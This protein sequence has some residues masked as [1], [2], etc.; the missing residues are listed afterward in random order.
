MKTDAPAT[1]YAP[2]YDGPIAGW[3]KNHMK[4]NFWRCERVSSREDYLQDAYVVF[5][6]CA[7]RYPDMDTPEHFMALFQRSWSN[8]VNDLSNKATA[9]KREVV[10]DRL[11]TSGDERA[12]EPAGDSNNDGEL[13]VMLRQAPSEVKQVLN[14]FLNAP[15][16]LLDLALASWR[17]KDKRCRAGGSK[18]VC[19]LLGLPEDMDVMQRVADYFGAEP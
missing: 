9:R 13:A 5:L 19:Q 15:Q 7:A 18:K 4:A 17:G 6:R 16:E 1:T 12:W 2:E 10:L 11:P 8:H 3:V 14:L